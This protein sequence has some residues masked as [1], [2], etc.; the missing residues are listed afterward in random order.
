[1]GSAPHATGPHQRPSPEAYNTSAPMPTGPY[2]QHHR[3]PSGAYNASAP[4]PMP[5]RSTPKAFAPPTGAS[6][7]APPF[8]AVAAVPNVWAAPVQPMHAMHPPHPTHAS[9]NA[10][11][12]DGGSGPLT[13]QVYNPSAS[14]AARSM[15]RASYPPEKS[16]KAS[17]GLRVCLVLLGVCFVVGT[18][19]AI[20]IGA[21]DDAPRAAKPA[22]TATSAATSAPAAE[23]PPQ[24]P[25]AAEDPG[26]ATA[27]SSSATGAPTTTVKPLGSAK[28]PKPAGSVPATLKG[29][30]VPPNPF[31]LPAKRK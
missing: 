10:I 21:A 15:S 20:V 9:A 22:S 24:A 28:V 13:Y 18:A 25:I 11:P 1:M 29:A 14:P 7:S 27:A 6:A 17:L 5:I 23:T 8:A 19:S 3:P 30:T 31:G 4:M 2:Q 26:L 16:S 12:K